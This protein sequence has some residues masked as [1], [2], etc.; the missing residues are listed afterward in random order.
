[1]ASI[2]PVRFWTTS[3]TPKRDLKFHQI[4]RFGGADRSKGVFFYF[5][6]EWLGFRT[7]ISVGESSHS[8]DL[9]PEH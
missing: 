9:T 3:A 5:F 7:Q 6:R 8:W 4:D 2:I 1:M